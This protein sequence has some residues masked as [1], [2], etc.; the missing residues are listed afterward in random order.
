MPHART[1]RFRP[2]FVIA[3]LALALVAGGLA[4]RHA[5]ASDHQDSPDVELNP[6][7]DMTDFY[8]FPGSAT[9]RIALV[10]NSWAFLTPASTP[11]VSFDPNLLYQIKIDNTGDAKE[12]LVM[13]VKFNGTG[14]SQ[15]VSLWGPIAPPVAGAMQNAV[16]TAA[17]ALTGKVNTLLGSASGIQ[18]FAGPRSDPFFI[19]LEQF[20]RILPDRKPVTGTL[21]QLPNTPTASAFRN[22]G[23]DFV[24]GHNVLSIVVELPTSML[25]GGGNTKIGLWGTIS[26]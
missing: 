16:S 7:M 24:A 11:N 21:S 9:G 13:Q 14:A 5:L 22:P 19:D 25:T 18:L 23:I 12:D 8:A 10:L 17:P 20:F 4:A 3:G 6:A 2:R 15:T 26:R 1:L